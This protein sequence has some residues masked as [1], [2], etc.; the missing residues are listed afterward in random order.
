MIEGHPQRTPLTPVA[1][2]F[3]ATKAGRTLTA[4]TAVAGLYGL[5]QGV[6]DGNTW[7]AAVA[8]AGVPVVALNTLSSSFHRHSETFAQKAGNLFAQTAAAVM[9]GSLS[10][11]CAHMT[12]RIDQ[13]TARIAAL[14]EVNATQSLTTTAKEL[15]C[16]GKT[17]VIEVK[18]PKR[19]ISG[20][21]NCAP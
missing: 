16:Q 10:F 5:A 17:A 2:S 18:D 14:P 20:K 15:Y 4:F 7:Q 19:G 11:Y 3:F 21:L 1:Q 8:G 9:Y 12:Q 6:I 13:N